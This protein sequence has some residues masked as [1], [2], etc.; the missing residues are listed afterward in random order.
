MSQI[1]IISSAVPVVDL[2]DLASP[3]RFR[4][5][6]VIDSLR[7]ACLD[8]GF[9]YVVGHGVPERMIDTTFEQAKRFFDQP[10]AS[11]QALDIALSHTRNRGYEAPGLQTLDPGSLP[12]LKEGFLIGVDLPY[13][14]PLVASGAYNRGPNQWPDLPDFKPAMNA[15]FDEMIRLSEALM[16]A[17]AMSLGMPED[18]FEDFNRDPVAVLRLLHYPPQPPQARPGEIG[19]GAHTDFG[20]VTLLMQDGVGGLQ[21]KDG[22]RG[23]IG[24]PPLRGSY[25][26]NL[27]DMMQRWTNGMYRSTLH[28]VVNLSGRERY[29]LPFFFDGNADYLV[30]CL[31]VCQSA[32]NPAKY[33]PITVEQHLRDCFAAT[34]R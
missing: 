26:V 10:D 9:L 14:H 3:Q 34:Y 21:V 30:E 5:D 17:M 29:S 24:A 18:Y 6:A 31:P 2:T 22:D 27:G 12:D 23:W 25:V 32:D 16:A 19:C 33:E 11:K 1:Q 4:R 7:A 8:K 15:Y 28:R 20:G 13:E